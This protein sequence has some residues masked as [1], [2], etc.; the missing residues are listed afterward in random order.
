MRL[1]Y[2]TSSLVILGGWNPNI[3]NDQWIKKNLLDRP[4]EQLNIGVSG[5]VSPTGIY[6]PIIDAVFSNVRLTVSGE[7]LELNLINSNDFTHI[8]DCVR[9]LCNC[10]PNTLVSGYGVN[11]NYV[12]NRVDNNLRSIFEQSNITQEI[13][14]ENHAYRINLD[15]IITTINID[16]N[17]RGNQSG[18]RFNF[19]FD[20]DTLSTLIQR[21]TEYP[22]VSLN[23][24]AVEFAL[25]QHGLIL[26]N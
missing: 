15:G 11:F 24:K 12:D 20:I 6:I 1:D 25:S 9:K 3:V 21:M 10:Q 13:I 17:N 22:I 8:E 14:T 23:E 5:N 19:H 26:E 18:L 2:K 4:N 16:I 7:R